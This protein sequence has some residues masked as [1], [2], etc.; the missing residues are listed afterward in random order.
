MPVEIQARNL[1]RNG[2][3]LVLERRAHKDMLKFVSRV[4]LHRDLVT[5]VV[6]GR[7]GT[8]TGGSRPCWFRFWFLFLPFLG[9][10]TNVLVD[11]VSQHIVIQRWNCKFYAHSLEGLF[12]LGLTGAL[13][14]YMH[15][16]PCLTMVQFCLDLIIFF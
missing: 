9:A 14:Q 3:N 11:V 10:C 12:L 8:M 5:P 6:K 4:F 16:T 2:T 15:F 13:L 7:G 1:P